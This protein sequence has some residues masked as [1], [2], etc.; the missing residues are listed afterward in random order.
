MNLDTRSGGLGGGTVGELVGGV[1]SGT[2]DPWASFAE[3]L[4]WDELRVAPTAGG[5]EAGR[6]ATEAPLAHAAALPVVR[7]ATSAAALLVEFSSAAAQETAQA[8]RQDSGGAGLS[9]SAA[10]ELANDPASPAGSAAGTRAQWR[11]RA[12][13]LG[14]GSVFV[15]AAHD[16]KNAAIPATS[17]ELLE[18][19]APQVGTPEPARLLS[20]AT[21]GPDQ[22]G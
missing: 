15:A 11:A 20:E 16:F 19:L 8:G 22:A 14:L 17:A 18:V 12:Q 6:S 5:L 1:S 2:T 3:Q 13:E 4:D 9:H 7:G 10:P 21:A